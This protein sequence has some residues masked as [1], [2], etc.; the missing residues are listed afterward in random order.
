LK[1]SEE[2]TEIKFAKINIEKSN[3][4]KNRFNISHIP[5]LILFH[6]GKLIEKHTGEMNYLDMKDFIMKL[7]TFK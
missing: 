3:L 4:E 2:I 5:T 1:L 6:N 7:S